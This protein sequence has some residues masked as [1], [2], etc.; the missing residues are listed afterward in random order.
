[1]KR[2]TKIWMEAMGYAEGDRIPCEWPLCSN[3]AVDVHHIEPRGMGGDPT[4]SKD[5]PE[6]L[7]G[8]CRHHHDQC[9]AKRWSKQEQRSIHLRNLKR[10]R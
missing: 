3:E 6:N 9:E 10:L 8:L 2:H 4:G 5:T 7:M 1:M